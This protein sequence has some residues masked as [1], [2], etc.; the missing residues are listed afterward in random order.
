ML[1][2]GYKIEFQLNKLCR[3]WVDMISEKILS[4]IKIHYPN[5][6]LAFKDE[7]KFMKLISKL[8]FWNKD[9]MTRFTTVI[10]DTIY[11][12][13]KTFLTA[14]PVSSVITL[15]H[16][17]VHIYDAHRLNKLLFYFLYST[18]QSLLLLLPII[19]FLSWKLS[20]LFIIFA[21]PIPSY[22]RMKYEKRAY[23]ASLYTMN[24]LNKKYN[25]NIDLKAQKDFYLENFKDSSYYFMWPFSNI[26]KE[27]EDA[28][29]KM[30][31]GER[32][33]EDE[34]FDLLDDILLEA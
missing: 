10:G 24:V 8:M 31:S 27:F 11:F 28:L 4:K 1:F 25:Y 12:P 16:E 3:K 17:T 20:L 32:P 6:N 26:D 9:F 5:V 14:R 30:Q 19:L 7:S 13:N 33:F 29:V 18:P 23:M 34:V 22:F 15:L 2:F 21:L